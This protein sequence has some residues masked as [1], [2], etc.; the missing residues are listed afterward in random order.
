[1]QKNT[2]NLKASNVPL[3]LFFKQNLMLLIN[4]F[5][6]KKTCYRSLSTERIWFK[7]WGIKLFTHSTSISISII[8]RRQ[9][10]QTTLTS[11][12]CITYYTNRSTSN[13]EIKPS[14]LLTLQMLLQNQYPHHIKMPMLL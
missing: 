8:L 10:K 7:I 5:H 2:F 9:E 3:N 11:V 1:M 13:M 12:H 14:T 4:Y 6:S